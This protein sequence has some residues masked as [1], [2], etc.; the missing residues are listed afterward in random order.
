MAAVFTSHARTRL[1]KWII[2]AACVFAA[3][4]FGIAQVAPGLITFQAGTAIVADE[5]NSNFSLL[6][7]RITDL[8]AELG[9]ALQELANLESEFLAIGLEGVPGP[10]GPTGE[11][12][13]RGDAGPA[14]PQGP[15][16]PAGAD[17]EQGPEGP[18]GPGA[19]RLVMNATAN[20]LGV[21][22]VDLPAEVGSDHNDPPLITCYLESQT[23][24]LYWR[25]IADGFSA[26]Q[27][28][29]IAGIAGNGNWFVGMQNLGPGQRASFV[30]LY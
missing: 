12:G 1:V 10:A 29:C 24:N 3:G 19:T 25:L 5:V 9:L 4:V 2:G 21:A 28:Y 14:G 7:N 26:S 15:A 22:V 23:P 13:E 11:R 8:R 20:S 30:V 16:G 17:G 6:E 27:A 18:I